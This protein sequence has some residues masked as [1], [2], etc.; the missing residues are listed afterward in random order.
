MSDF[1]TDFLQGQ[2]DCKS[3]IEYQK[4]VSEFY[5]RGYDAQQSLDQVVEAMRKDKCQK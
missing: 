1:V 5:T 4:G 3:G 2:Q